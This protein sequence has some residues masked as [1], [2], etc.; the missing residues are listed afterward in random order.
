MQQI[1]P[2]KDR[3]LSQCMEALE[4][5]WH[6]SGSTFPV[7]TETTTSAGTTLN[8]A[9]SGGEQ[10]TISQTPGSA[11]V[12]ETIPGGASPY[13]DPYVTGDINHDG[14]VDSADLLY[15]I[16]N[17]NV[18]GTDANSASILATLQHFNQAV[19]PTSYIP[20]SYSGSF[21]EIDVT[22]VSGD[23][24]VTLDSS[25]TDPAVLQGGSGNDKLTAGPGTTTL[26]AGTGA[27]TLIAGS[28]SDT[29]IALNSLPDTLEGGS[30]VDSF[31]TTSESTL[32][33]VST[34]ETAINA[35]HTLSDTL[36]AALSSGTAA[37]D[38][39]AIGNSGGIYTSFAADPLFSSTG[40]N[41]F[42]VIQG[43]LG[44]CWYMASLGAVAQTDPNQI[45]QDVVQLSDGTFLVRF[46]SGGTPVY[47][48]VDATL[49]TNS[50]G[51]LLFAQLG[52]GN[53]IWA[54][55]MEKALAA[56]RDGGNS[57]S[58]LGSGWMDEAYND[59]GIVNSNA[60]Y[61]SSA[62]QMFQQ[63]Q[64]ELEGGQAVTAGTLSVPSGTPLVAN[65]AYSVVAVTTDANGDLTGLELR[66]PWGIVGISGYA[67][68]N[69]Y[70]TITPAQAFGSIAGTTAGVA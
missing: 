53:S 11:V 6:L 17:Y 30:G 12:T 39:P 19:P 62:N 52:Q 68:N 50:G 15:E 70:V 66:N 48:H 61:F 40:P 34:T 42:D 18:P 5:R 67:G 56:F 51:G 49:P 60:F 22:C 58:N 31:W 36:A 27:S 37:L 21:A 54:P 57:Y 7:V 20:S 32:L 13:T 44:D 1:K 23:N 4:C 45:R 69:G 63:I 35:V 33:N 24:N 59:L 38:S 9:V 55:I 64:T 14:M 41:I 8:V 2:R 26:Y 29:L 46:F 25:V 65:H 47:E 16:Q 10:V 3:R 43:N 28:G